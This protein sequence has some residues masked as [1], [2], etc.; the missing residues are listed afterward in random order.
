MKRTSQFKIAILRA[1]Q[2]GDLLCAIPAIRSLRAAYPD[3][4]ITLLGLP[5]AKSFVN[6]FSEYLDK[7][8]HFPGYPGLPEQ[9]YS[10]DAWAQ[11]VEIM[12]GE[13]FD[14]VI[15][16]QGNGTIVNSMLQNLDIKQLAG[17]YHADCRVDSNLFI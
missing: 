16:M 1:L 17:F 4:E 5:W 11:F 3:A 7:F 15:Q 8:I 10:P 13:Q 2:L 12:H 9:S 14:L 6:R